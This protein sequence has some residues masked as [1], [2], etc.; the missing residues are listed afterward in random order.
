MPGGVAELEGDG[1]R[2]VVAER[3]ALA[4]VDAHDLE[5]GLGDRRVDDLGA[6]R[7]G[8]LEVTRQEVGVEVGLDD[9]FDGEAELRGV[10]EVLGHVALRVDDDGPPGRLVTDQ[11]R[12]V[13][14]TL[15]VVLVEQHARSSC[16]DK[17]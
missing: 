17:G 12:R 7:L 2:A 11:V 16:P 1:V 5:L 3:V 9:Q 13:R 14:Q 6:R 10:G 8:E 15:Q 4:V